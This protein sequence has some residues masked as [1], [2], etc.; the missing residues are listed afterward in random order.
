[1]HSANDANTSAKR[2]KLDTDLDPPSS[3]RSTRSSRNARPDIY[4]IN[5]DDQQETS[6]GDLPNASIEQLEVTEAVVDPTAEEPHASSPPQAARTPSLPAQVIDEVEESPADAPGNS[7]RLRTVFHAANITSIEL[8][9]LQESS[10]AGLETETP[11]PRRKR[12]RGEISTNTLP[13]TISR[14]SRSQLAKVAS[15]ISDINELSPEQPIRRGRRA[16]AV[17][18]ETSPDLDEPSKV[19]DE[20]EEA[21]AIDDEEA[22]ALLKKN[23]GRR[24][25]RNVDAESP[26]LD[27]V[28][29]PISPVAKKRKGKARIDSNPVKR[30]P[31]VKQNAKQAVSRKFGKKATIRAGSPI[32]VTVHRLTR[33]LVY[34]EEEADADILNAEIPHTKRGGVNAI[35]VLSQICQEI[36]GAGLDTLEDGGSSCED[37]ALRREYKTKWRA[38]EAFGKELQTRLLEHVGISHLLIWIHTETFIDDKS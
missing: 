30:H 18:E 20:Q 3:G 16:R 24:I 36:V 8:Q 11:I 5:G 23:R 13:E 1:V 12:K 6:I 33:P 17:V 29:A 38:V 14:A 2:R 22:A 15:S 10:P 35:D 9:G 21:E 26:S 19:S 27:E 4:S 28:E 37:P 31:K 25:S 32:P 7:Q 34:D